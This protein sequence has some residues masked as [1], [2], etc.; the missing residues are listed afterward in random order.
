MCLLTKSRP[1]QWLWF[2]LL[3]G[4]L[5]VAAVAAEIW[6][7]ERQQLTPEKL[8]AA[9]AR[10]REKG[11]RDYALDYEVKREDHPDPAPRT[12]ERHTVLVKDGR[13]E[14]PGAFEFGSVD[15]LFDR[16]AER[17]E[18]DRQ[19]GGPRPFVKAT[20]DPDDG[21][22]VHYVRS[23][24]KTRERLEIGVTLRPLTASSP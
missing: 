22:V 7:N 12:G 6:S 23:V 9:R 10:W 18:A 15:D 21:H 8:A 2:F 1:K 20:F 3:I 14:R 17:L 5:A 11:L 13:A 24:M 16:I 4:T 19:S